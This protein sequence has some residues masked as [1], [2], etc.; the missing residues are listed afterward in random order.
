M[1]KSKSLKMPKRSAL[2]LRPDPHN[3]RK[4]NERNQKMI[5]QSLEEVGGFRSIAV[6][7]DGI[8]RAGNGV[9]E[10]AQALGMK[11]RVVDARPD[12]VIA[13][14]RADLKGKKA[15]RA[16]ILDN[17]AGELSE[18]DL[19]VL[20][21]TP[22]DLLAGLWD[23]RELKAMGMNGDGNADAEPQLDRAAELNEKWQVKRGD[24]FAI[25]DH[26]LLCGDCTMREDVERVMGKTDGQI[27]Q[28]CVTSP[29]YG[30]GKSYETKGIAAWFETVRPAIKNLCSASDIVC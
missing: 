25:G 20:A 23:E 17:R 26:R 27:A 30:V 4:H 16:A 7:G 24:L 6:D 29:P 10:Q 11:V 22:D 5:R 8:V 2:N 18:W 1:P 19:D 15:V 28:L 9:F 13:V 12:E 14:R 3:A 21:A